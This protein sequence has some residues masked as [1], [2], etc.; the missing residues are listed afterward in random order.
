MLCLKGYGMQGKRV[1]KAIAALYCLADAKISSFTAYP[2]PLPSPILSETPLY[3]GGDRDGAKGFDAVLNQADTDKK[4][5]SHHCCNR[6]GGDLFYAYGAL[7]VSPLHHHH[8]DDDTSDSLP[9]SDPA[10]AAFWAAFP[11]PACLSQDVGM[12]ADARASNPTNNTLIVAANLWA[13]RNLTSRLHVECPRQPLL[14]Q[15]G[16][17]SRASLQPMAPGRAG[18]PPSRAA[19]A[20][21]VT[22]GLAALPPSGAVAGGLQAHAVAHVK[23]GECLFYSSGVVS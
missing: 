23:A 10:A 19:L 13:G 4:E 8:P 3:V 14:R 7:D 21:R 11:P 12:S 22:V 18:P 6:K 1:G 2:S 15:P 17:Q 20:C 16:Q 5:M 9:P